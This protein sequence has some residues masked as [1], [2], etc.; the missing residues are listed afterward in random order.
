[1]TFFYFL[2]K[3]KGWACFFSG[4]FGGREGFKLQWDATDVNRLLELLLHIG[5]QS[6]TLPLTKLLQVQH[7]ANQTW[8]TLPAHQVEANQVSFR[9][10]YHGFTQYNFTSVQ[11]TYLSLYVEHLCDIYFHYILQHHASTERAKKLRGKMFCFA[12]GLQDVI[13]RS[14]LKGSHFIVLSR[15]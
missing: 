3:N 9:K 1:M 6:I 14:I 8:C 12:V 15:F 10:Q 7:L 4:W 11:V 13:K 5:H 2:H